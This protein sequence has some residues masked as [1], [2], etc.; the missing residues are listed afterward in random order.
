MSMDKKRERYVELRKII[1]ACKKDMAICL[2]NSQFSE[3]ERLAKKAKI[4]AR[5][6]LYLKTGKE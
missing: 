1:E 2:S 5:E 4:S 6:I 3:L